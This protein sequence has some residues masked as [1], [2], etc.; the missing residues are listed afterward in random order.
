MRSTAMPP[1]PR[2]VLQFAGVFLVSFLA[3]LWLYPKVLP[4]W[5]PMPIGLANNLMRG[6]SPPTVIEAVPTGGWQSYILRGGAREEFYSW[7]EFVKH[8]VYLNL[9]L[10]PALL[11]ATPVGWRKRLMLLGIGLAALV[12]VHALS[13]VTLVRG[14]I[15]LQSDAD[16][17][18]CNF[19]LR[20]AYA[21]GQITAAL[22]WA[23]LTWKHWLPASKVPLRV[24]VDRKVGRNE[25]CP[26]GS[27]RKY[28]RCCGRKAG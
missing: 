4:F 20:G 18:W 5:E 25:P 11:L 7:Q 13:L 24:K 28:K 26:C 2:K 1:S 19:L 10:L 8:L 3:L 15:C 22:L 16:S 6:Q 14:Y 12:V 27:G 9:A 23:A 21:S 17:F